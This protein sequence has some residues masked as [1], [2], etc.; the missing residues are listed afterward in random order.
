[1]YL[2]D[3]DGTLIDTTELIYRCFVNTCRAYGDLRI[4]RETIVSHIGLPLRKQLEIYLGALTDNVAEE[5][6]AFHMNYQLSIY[7]QYL[8]LFP[9]VQQGLEMLRHKG[10]KL[11]IVTSRML[12]TLE[13]YTR[14]L[15]I[16]DYFDAIVTPESTTLHKPAPEPAYKALELLGARSKSEALFIGDAIY[17]IKCGHD[18]GLDTAFVS[19][20]HNDPVTFSVSPTYIV[21]EFSELLSA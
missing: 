21:K 4:D 6:R 7:D 10:K 5:I 3:A 11:A 17:D 18:A 9:G 16:Y 14:H 19:W 15:K 1:Y 13:H 2:F 20:S 8:A 12:E